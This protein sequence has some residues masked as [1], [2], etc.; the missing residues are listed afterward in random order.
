MVSTVM[1]MDKIEDLRREIAQ[2]EAELEDL[3]A[4][5]A[6]A[7][8]EKSSVEDAGDE[9][10]SSGEGWKWPLE[11]HEYERYSRQMIV[12]N[13]GLQGIYYKSL[14]FSCHYIHLHVGRVLRQYRAAQHQKRKGAPRRRGRAGMPGSGLSRGRGRRHAG[15]RGRRR[16]RG[17]ESASAGCAFDGESGH[18]E[19]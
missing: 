11:K 1:I 18:D 9:T 16:G 12:P 15:A 2:R 14:F 5:L 7:E 3:R 10:Q 8:A 13:F 17:V 4:R 19:G 6:V